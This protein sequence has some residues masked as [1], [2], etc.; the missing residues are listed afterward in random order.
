MSFA[1]RRL[2]LAKTYRG[3]NATESTKFREEQTSDEVKGFQ[4]ESTT[5][6]RGEPWYEEKK[7]KTYP[8]QKQEAGSTLKIPLVNSSARRVVRGEDDFIRWVKVP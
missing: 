5:K 7:P 3:E 1:V 4:S 6:N 8:C 2:E